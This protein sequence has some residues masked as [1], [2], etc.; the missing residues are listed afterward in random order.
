MNR[1]LKVEKH[2]LSRSYDSQRLIEDL[3]DS[4]YSTS[5]QQKPFLVLMP[6]EPESEKK[7]EKPSDLTKNTAV[8]PTQA[9]KAG[10]RA[11]LKKY[12]KS[13][14]ANQK[15]L[16]HQIQRS[17]NPSEFPLQKHIARYGI[18]QFH[19]YIGLHKLWRQYMSDLL[20]GEQPSPA[21][22]VL[23]PKLSSADYNGCMLTVLESR[24][25]FLIG[26]CGIVI[27][28]SQHSFIVVVE[29]K[30]AANSEKSVSPN[31]MVGG[32]KVLPKRHTLFGFDVDHEGRKVA[33]TM[34]GSRFELRSADRSARK[35]KSHNVADVL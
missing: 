7:S 25:P 14:Q 10:V 30:T 33:F 12:I 31:E 24:N 17:S 4:R 34:I 20:F 19:Q 3:L 8:K 2:L 13:V 15:R 22:T 1:E 26:S 35:F 18:P 23:L 11:Q 9:R 29:A 32:L 16:V 5:G 28:E 6:N 27:Y 21:P